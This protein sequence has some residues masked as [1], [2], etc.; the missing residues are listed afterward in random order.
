[1]TSYADELKMRS[2]QPQTKAKAKS[3]TPMGEHSGGQISQLVGGNSP[4]PNLGNVGT[5]ANQ[6]QIPVGAAPASTME[7]TPN[8]TGQFTYM[9]PTAE[10][11]AI[12]GQKQPD[13]LGTANSDM[14]KAYAPVLTDLTNQGK[15]ATDNSKYNDAQLAA[16]YGALQSSIGKD[17][18][19]LATNNQGA[20]TALQGIGSGASAAIG[21]NYQG[22]NQEVSDMMKKLGIEQAAGDVLPRGA[23]S[24][25]FLQGISGVQ[26]QGAQDLAKQLATNAQNFTTQQQNIA[27]FEG[28]QN[29]VANQKD[30]GNKLAQLATQRAQVGTQAGTQAASLASTLRGQFMDSLASRANAL[31]NAYGQQNQYNLAQQQGQQQLALAQQNNNLE[32]SKLALSRTPTA[33]QQ[34]GMAGTGQQLYSQASQIYG[35]NV[36]LAS[37]AINTAMSID[38]ATASSGL[39]YAKKVREA[40]KNDPVLAAQPDLLN[41]LALSFYKESGGKPNAQTY[42]SSGQ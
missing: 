33:Q 26:S 12:Y 5:V 10:I 38:P 1:M 34:Y 40:A 18:S 41:Q 32:M 42:Y 29:R 6:N 19:A 13:F 20:L 28:T 24:Q 2:K 3:S 7:P 21:Q 9:D 30:L 14:Q 39:D 36:D 25:A 16:M 27:G 11:N 31:I 23:D 22:A 37:K 15:K 4:T 17:N 35:G 8:A